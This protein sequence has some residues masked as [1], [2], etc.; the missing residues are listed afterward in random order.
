[1][2]DKEL[3]EQI[4]HWLEDESPQPVRMTACRIIAAGLGSVGRSLNAGGYIYRDDAMRGLGVVIEMG[5][6]LANGA[7]QLL[8]QELWYAGGSL[9][10][11]L[12]EVEYLTSRFSEDWAAAASW[13]ASSPAEIRKQFSPEAMRH[14]SGGRFRDAEYWQH[15][16]IGGHP[17]P[18]GQLLLKDHS[19]PLASQT[20]LWA[21]LACHLER[22]WAY[23]LSALDAGNSGD[24]VGDK[25]RHEVADVVSE[26]R[27]ADS[28]MDRLAATTLPSSGP[29][30]APRHPLSG[31]ELRARRR[32]GF[33]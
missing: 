9:L 20:W 6:E 11:Q 12:I 3:R 18:K 22:L 23:V 16:D 29:Q 28:A 19:S 17:S 26:W 4:K 24:L 5:A 25:V 1:M 31:R 33:Q 8:D 2:D 30:P 32:E 27:A 10:R 13:L 14:A 7:V 21:D 15:C